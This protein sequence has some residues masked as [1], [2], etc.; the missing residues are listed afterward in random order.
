MKVGFGLLMGWCSPS[1]HAPLLLWHSASRLVLKLLPFPSRVVVLAMNHVRVNLL[2]RSYRPMPQAC[3]H[4]RQR[5]ATS[6]QMRAMRVP[7]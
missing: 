3:G 6:E 5:Y 7:E 1:L 2:R 4:S